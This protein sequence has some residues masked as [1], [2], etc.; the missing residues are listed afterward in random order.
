MQC[1]SVSA[2]AK[3]VLKKSST[4]VFGRNCQ[5]AYKINTLQRCCVSREVR[6]RSDWR[7]NFKDKHKM[8]VGPFPGT[9]RWQ[10]SCF[11]SLHL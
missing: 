2:K 6:E 9:D 5:L 7:R 3:T 1:S 11:P 8:H 10:F 4:A